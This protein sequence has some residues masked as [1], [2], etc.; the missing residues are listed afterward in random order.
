MYWPCAAEEKAYCW[1]A[2]RMPAPLERESLTSVSIR[3]SWAAA[4][5]GLTSGWHFLARSRYAAFS[6]AREAP[7][8]TPSTA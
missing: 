6:S 7:G 3:N 5:V 8:C 4:W 1:S 2:A